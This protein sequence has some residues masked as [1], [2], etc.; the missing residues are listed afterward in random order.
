MN[1]VGYGNSWQCLANIAT[2]ALVVIPKMPEMHGV[3]LCT[4]RRHYD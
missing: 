1:Y 2:V 4:L 3:R